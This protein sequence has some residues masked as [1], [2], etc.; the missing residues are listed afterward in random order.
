MAEQFIDHIADI[1]AHHLRAIYSRRICKDSG[2]DPKNR[3][4]VKKTME[5]SK[6]D[7]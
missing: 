5:R 1:V 2:G 4:F 6:A 7:I 3:P